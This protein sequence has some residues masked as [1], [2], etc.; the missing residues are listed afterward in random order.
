MQKDKGGKGWIT[1]RHK[2]VLTLSI[3]GPYRSVPSGYMSL[4]F[5]WTW[6]RGD[7][8]DC[9]IL[10]A[11]HPLNFFFLTNAVGTRDGNREDS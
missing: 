2:C 1:R 8:E 5:T 9:G 11:P 6:G 10:S 4:F 7:R 3:T